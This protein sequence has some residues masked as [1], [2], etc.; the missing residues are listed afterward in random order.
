MLCAKMSGSTIA[1][2]PS[3]HTPAYHLLGLC[4]RHTKQSCHKFTAHHPNTSVRYTMQLSHVHCPSYNY[5]NPTLPRT[6]YLPPI[7]HPRPRTNNYSELQPPI[8]HDLDPTT[9]QVCN[10]PSSMTSNQ[11]LLRAAT[12]HHRRPRPTEYTQSGH[13]LPSLIHTLLMRD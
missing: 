2:S 5:I 8:I 11:Q 1:T 12:C 3:S 4:N 9:T 10:L 7:H 13:L 6:D